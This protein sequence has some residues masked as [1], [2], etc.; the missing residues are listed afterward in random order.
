M[1]TLLICHDDANLDRDGLSRWLASFSTLAGVLVVREP[2]SRLRK[3]VGREIRRVGFWRFL[4]VVAFRAYYQLAWASDDRRTHERELE[5]LRA[6]YPEYPGAPELIVDS[7]NS[8]EAEAF[9]RRCH[10]DLALAR[11]KTLLKERVFSIA[12]LGTYALHPGICP[13]YRNAHGC[14]WAVAL[15][16]YGNV[17]TTLLRIDAGVDTGPVFGHFRVEADPG[18]SHVTL[19]HRAVLDHLDAIRETLMAIEGRTA[20]PIETGGRPSATWGQP[21]LT[22]LVKRRLRERQRTG[23]RLRSEGSRP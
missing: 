2:P 10:P 1:R 21:W 18:E 20:A 12:P 16:D 13:E 7:P 22:A 6:C 19:Q 11:C 8:V 23:G 4:D 3:R 14:F 17:G 9:V 15:G 5:W